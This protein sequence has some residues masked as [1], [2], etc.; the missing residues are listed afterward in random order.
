MSLS[1][2]SDAQFDETAFEAQLTEDRV[3]L[4]SCGYW[5]LKREARFLAG[6]YGA[7]LAAFQEA[8][9]RLWYH[10]GQFQLVNYFYFSALTVAALYEYGSAEEQSEWRSA[11]GASGTAARMG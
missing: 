6:D 9:P 3:T 4:L 2:F 5:I 10:F 7:A 11:E 1:S 8:R